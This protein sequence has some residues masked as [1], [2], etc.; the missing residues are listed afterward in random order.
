MK[1]M[2]A[3][4]VVLVAGCGEATPPPSEAHVAYA[5]ACVA[6]GDA[7]ALCECWADKIDTLVAD[8]SVSEQVQRAFLLQAQGKEDE[9][10]AIMVTL[11]PG[12][13]LHQPIAIAEAQKQCLP[14][15]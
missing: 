6:A 5:K 8:G 4:A 13:L 14:P 11:P 1:W 2:V 3:A 15:G 10:D 12:D 9:A 7:E